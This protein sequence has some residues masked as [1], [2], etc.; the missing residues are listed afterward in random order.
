MSLDL[1]ISDLHL[2]PE[3]PDIT[4]RFRAFVEGEARRAERLFILGDL[5]ESWVGDDED[6]ALAETV[7]TSLRALAN[8]GTHC[9]FMIG[10]RD[11]LLGEAFCSRAGMQILTEPH[12]ELIDGVDTVLLHGDA[13]CTD[14]HSYQ[15]FRR[16][17]RD[18]EW[19]RTFLAKPIDERRRLARAAR[20][21]S[22]RHTSAA[23]ETIMDVNADAV[24]ALFAHSH[25]RRIIHGHTHRPHYHA[26]GTAHERIVLGDWYSQGSALTITESEVKLSTPV[27]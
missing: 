10:N 19:Q 24:R 4:A 9:F 20:M 13:L 27:E 5:F 2:D 6:S 1:F 8:A 15:A 3:R 26:P 12:Q 22:Q 16:M 21:Q 7:A 25:A 17:V 14:D 11:F 18:P 23:S